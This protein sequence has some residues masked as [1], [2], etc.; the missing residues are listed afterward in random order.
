MQRPW[1]PYE[2]SFPTSLKGMVALVLLGLGTVLIVGGSERSTRTA[3]AV[4][5]IVSAVQQ[6]APHPAIDDG[7]DIAYR[8]TVG[9]TT[10]SATTFRT[11]GLTAIQHAKVC[12][13]PADPRNEV[14]V[15]IND[16][17]D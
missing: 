12:Y 6:L 9:G 14:L 10:Y 3:E 5:E 11:W 16:R 17:C 4:P 8:F 7:Y 1:R 15:R 13:D 2:P